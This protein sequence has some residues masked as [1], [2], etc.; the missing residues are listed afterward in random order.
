MC[1]NGAE[2]IRFGGGKSECQLDRVKNSE[3]NWANQG[4]RYNT[5]S[6]PGSRASMARNFESRFCLLIPACYF[7]AWSEVSSR[8]RS[9]RLWT[10]ISS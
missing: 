6:L 4:E 1:P 9:F 2:I 8:S 3:S 5:A 10:R 7:R